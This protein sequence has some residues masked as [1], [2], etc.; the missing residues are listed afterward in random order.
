MAKSEDQQPGSG[1]SSEDHEQPDPSPGPSIQRTVGPVEPKQFPAFLRS[2]Q[3]AINGILEA[4]DVMPAL[5][6]MIQPDLTAEEFIGVLLDLVQPRAQAVRE[7]LR[8]MHA[9]IEQILAANEH[10]NSRNTE[11]IARIN[12]LEEAAQYSSASFYS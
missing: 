10:L 9:R 3:I 6:V 12:E 4:L 7:E 1:G 5:L 8:K 2:R 11:Y